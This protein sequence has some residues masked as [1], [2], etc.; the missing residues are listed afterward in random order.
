MSFLDRRQLLPSPTN[1]LANADPGNTTR[2]RKARNSTSLEVY[3]HGIGSAGRTQIAQQ[4]LQ[5]VKDVMK[6]A[7]GNELEFLDEGLESANGSAAKAELVARKVSQFVSLDERIIAQ[8][9][10]AP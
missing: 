4:Q 3:C 1:E 2:G 8:N 6:M 10:G 9:F 7:L 5:A